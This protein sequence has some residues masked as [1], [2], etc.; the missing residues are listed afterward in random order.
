MSLRLWLI[1]VVLLALATA[2]WWFYPADGTEKW[3]YQIGGE[4]IAAPVI[5][6]DRTIY[7]ASS[8][9]VALTPDGREIWAKDTGGTVR[10]GLL[11]SNDSR[12]LLVES[13][14]G[15][16]STI[17]ALD[18]S[19]GKRL[20]LYGVSG[21]AMEG[22][23]A[24]AADGTIYVGGAALHALAPDGTVL[25]EAQANT[26]VR[27]VVAPDGTVILATLGGRVT[28]LDPHGSERWVFESE[29]GFTSSP[30]ID[31]DGTVYAMNH[32]GHLL[33]ISSNGQK[34]WDRRLEEGDLAAPVI[35]PHG[36]LYVAGGSDR[37]KGRVYAVLTRSGALLWDMDF[38][39]PVSPPAIASDGTVYLGTYAQALHAF[40][41][42]AHSH[43]TFRAEA[44]F[45]IPVIADNGTVIIGTNNG[46]IYAIRSSSGKLANT[47]WPKYGRDLRNSGR[48]SQ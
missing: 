7:A 24:I 2:G 37:G 39:G 12:T 48:A 20:W 44:M 41:S 29:D 33:A 1:V 46:W 4:V 45:G 35:A 18:A 32:S 9:V 14:Q 47:A 11:L 42:K 28:A 16:T 27:P 3:R 5:G 15:G 19:T 21:P 38:S 25:W 30:T 36:I 6:S 26:N 10:G 22:S 34:L 40:D 17:F 23:A 43:W 13:W 8:K 31:A